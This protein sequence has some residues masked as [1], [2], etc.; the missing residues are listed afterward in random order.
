MVRPSWVPLLRV[1]ASLGMGIGHA[2]APVS[3]LVLPGD[4]RQASGTAAAE[5]CKGPQ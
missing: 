1:F 3:S 5:E 4:R 2:G